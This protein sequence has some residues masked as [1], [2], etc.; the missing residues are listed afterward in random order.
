MTILQIL[1]KQIHNVKFLNKV[2]NV[3]QG[4]EDSSNFSRG[5]EESALSPSPRWST[6]ARVS[7]P[8]GPR[9]NQVLTMR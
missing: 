1:A 2:W 9:K 5:I 7:L 8:L 3:K 6:R 4:L